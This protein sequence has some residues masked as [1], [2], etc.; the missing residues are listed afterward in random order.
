MFRLNFMLSALFMAWAVASAVECAP[1][2]YQDATG[3]HF[4]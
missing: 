3:F 4:A 2:G 1:L